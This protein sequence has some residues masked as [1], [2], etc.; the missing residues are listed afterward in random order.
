[1]PSDREIPGSAAD[2]LARARADL[3]M[4]QAPLPAGAML[5]SLCFHA[6]QAAE[7]AIKAVC[8]THGHGF[9]YTHNIGH[10]LHGLELRGHTVP[11]EIWL[12]SDLTRFAWEARYPGV[13]E[14]VTQDEYREALA[15]AQS[16]VR[17]AAAIVEGDAA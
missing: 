15:M 11:D 1:M 4:A 10:L 14:P 17:W 9:D 12:A 8:K 13:R 3:A 2:W 5:E 7:K 6:Q 16:V